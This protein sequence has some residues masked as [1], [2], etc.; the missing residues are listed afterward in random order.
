MTTDNLSKDQKINAVRGLVEDTL[1]N[2]VK[3][4]DAVRVTAVVGEHNVIFEVTM[5][6][7]DIGRAVGT[8]G[9]YKKHLQEILTA[10]SMNHGLRYTIDRV[11]ESRS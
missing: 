2:L 7:E 4:P 11:R 6:Q 3:N 9:A 1:R 8:N 10:V 5:P